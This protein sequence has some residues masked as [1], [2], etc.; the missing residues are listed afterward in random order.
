MTRLIIGGVLFLVLVAPIGHAGGS[1]GKPLIVAHV[2]SENGADRLMTLE[3]VG[4]RQSLCSR[5]AVRGRAG[6]DAH[7][8]TTWLDTIAAIHDIGVDRVTVTLKDGTL[9][10][11]A[12]VPDNRVLYF[13]DQF[14]RQQ[15]IELTGLKSIEFQTGTR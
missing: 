9:R 4:C 8:S 7:V 6:G 5:V 2:T 15:K 12:I 11:L 3:G 1:P 10:R 14:G 13:I